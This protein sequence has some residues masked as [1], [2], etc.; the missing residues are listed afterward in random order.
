MGM[1][2]NVKN[3]DTCRLA[4]EPAQL[5]D[6]KDTTMTKPLISSLMLVHP[7]LRGRAAP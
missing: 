1:S 4:D 2:L 6:R 7:A 3:D 5:T